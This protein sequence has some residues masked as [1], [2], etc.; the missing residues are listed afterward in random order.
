MPGP[1]SATLPYTHA[2]MIIAD[3]ARA[4]IGSV[5]LST[6]STTDARELGIFF[7][8]PASIQMITT[9]F[10]SDWAQ[11]VTPPAASAANCPATTTAG[12]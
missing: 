1:P 3:G 9:A 12:E 2:K 11:S 10:E 7:Q 5:N 6:A 4:Y 8:D